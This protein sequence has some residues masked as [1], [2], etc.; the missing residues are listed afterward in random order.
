MG[1]NT[2][3]DFKCN[4]T[5]QDIFDVTD[6]IINQGLNKLGYRYVNMD[7]CWAQGRD[8]NGQIYPDPIAFPNGIKVIADYVHSKGL[9]FGLYTD[10]GTLTCARRP[11]SQD[12][13]EIDAQTYASWGVDY[14]KDDSCHAPVGPTKVTAYQQYMKMRD[15]LNA[16]GRPIYFSLCGW[17]SWYAPVGQALGNSWRIS[18]DC[19]SWST[20]LIAIDNN[21]P[22]F[23]YASAGG[24]NDPDMLI[25]SSAGS[26]FSVTPIQSRAQFSLWA[27]MAAPLLIGS[28]IRHP[29]PWDLET[30]SNTEVISVDQD[31]LGKQGIRL[32]GG[33]LMADPVAPF[34]IWGRVLQ[35]GDV[36]IFFFNSDPSKIQD[37][38]CDI[39]CFAQVLGAEVLNPDNT[40]SVRDLWTHTNNGTVSNPITYTVRG[41]VP[42]GGHALLRFSLQKN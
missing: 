10:R 41:V 27:V 26:S 5:A 24:W 34:N 1:Y 17:R 35:N 14:V 30:Y 13:E 38:T 4:I 2:W 11:G 7:D 19:L 29:T 18:G 23:P 36:V 33:T 9:L 25:G 21:A 28:N 42:D 40:W 37:I 31:P 16:T 3:N 32:A 12:Y 8:K 39:S 20:I 6:A 22:L 15:A